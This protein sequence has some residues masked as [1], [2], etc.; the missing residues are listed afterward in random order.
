LPG[1]GDAEGVWLVE[2]P[3]V[4]A[5]DADIVPPFELGDIEDIPPCMV[6][7]EGAVLPEDI[8]GAAVVGDDIDE[9]SGAGPGVAVWASAK[10]AEHRT[11]SVAKDKDRILNS[12]DA[13]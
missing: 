3:S 5:G 2:E 10:P 13:W 7:E 1:D 8:P 11:A 4:G 12:C 9:L 6:V